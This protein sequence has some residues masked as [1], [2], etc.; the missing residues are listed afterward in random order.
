M[1]G[2]LNRVDKEIWPSHRDPSA[3][4]LSAVSPSSERFT[5]EG[6]T[7]ETSALESLYGG[8]IIN[9]VGKPNIRFHSLPT[10]Q[11]VFVR[12]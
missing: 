11:Y 1:F 4:L 3:D 2:F 12:N 10:Q 8:R 7:L 5:D 6:L 9:S